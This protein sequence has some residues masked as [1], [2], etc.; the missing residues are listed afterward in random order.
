[1]EKLDTN[2]S[3]SEQEVFA[4]ESEP[5]LSLNIDDLTNQ[6]SEMNP[7]LSRVWERVKEQKDG[8]SAHSRHS[9][10]HSHGQHN[11]AMW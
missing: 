10:H 7:K 4:L 1:M 8:V 6:Q 3:N 11:S 2:I 9:S 5:I